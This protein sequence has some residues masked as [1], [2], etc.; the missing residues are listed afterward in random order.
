MA[1][2]RFRSVPAAISTGVAIKTMI[3]LLAATNQ[4]VKVNEASMS[5]NGTSNTNAPIYV[6][7]VKQ[8]SAGTITNTTALTKED[9][10]YA[11]TIQTVG[12]DTATVEPTDS[13]AVLVAEYVHPQTG[14]LWQAPYGYELLIVGA[15]RLGFR[16]TAA[17]SVS[18]GSRLVC[19]E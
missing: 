1:G 14:F 4:R 6:E 7:L 19:E 8:T 13:G 17:N 16:Q 15:G 9:A 11:E 2:L 10:A 18:A 3:Q 5:F 12:K